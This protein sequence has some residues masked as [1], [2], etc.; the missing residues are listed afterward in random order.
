[1]PGRLK[2]IGFSTWKI[3]ILCLGY[4]IGVLQEDVGLDFDDG[5]LPE[6]KAVPA[7]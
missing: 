6:P 5:V 7:G 2:R 3:W 4:S 1:M